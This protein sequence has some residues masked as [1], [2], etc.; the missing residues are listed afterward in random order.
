LFL[1]DS[2]AD[3]SKSVIAFSLEADLAGFAGLA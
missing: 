1:Y 3:F 2:H